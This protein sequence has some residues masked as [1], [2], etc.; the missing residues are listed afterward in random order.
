MIYEYAV[1]PELVK[2]WILKRDV[3]LAGY[4]GM[5]QRRI[6]SDVAGNWEI[7]IFNLVFRHFG[8]DYYSP[9]FTEANQFLQ[10]LM[11][12]MQQAVNRG[13][14]RSEPWIDQVLQVN[15]VEPF[16]AIL[17]HSPIHECDEVITQDVIRDLTNTHW[18]LPSIKVTKKTAIGIADQL[19]TLLRLSSTL[20]LV[21]YY[22]EPT[23]KEYCDTLATLLSK[24]VLSRAPGRS[25]PNVT[26]ISS[27][28]HR[29]KSTESRAFSSD[30]QYLN[31]AN[32]RCANA[33]KNL[34]AFIPI[35][36][37]IIFK[38]I[39]AFKDG[40]EMHNRYLLTDLGGA[41]IPYGFDQKGENVF[42]DIAP[43]YKDQYEKRWKQYYKS[44]GLNIIGNPVQIHGQMK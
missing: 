11:Q 25:L 7:E 8:E 36:M 41:C 9:E 16:H 24:A 28:D 10:A 42:D 15:K 13:M 20:V 27:V 2:D 44:E 31:T 21:D 23:K 1:D 6:V 17:T 34:G 3:G 38:C 26:V 43:L 19:S 33:K 4:F 22:F 18:Y 32:T 39:S 29:N 14:Q 5:D 35:G 40:D 37:S 30:L 12:C